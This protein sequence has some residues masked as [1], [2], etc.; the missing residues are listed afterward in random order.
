[1]WL[2]VETS[3]GLAGALTDFWILF[4]WRCSSSGGVHRLLPL[5]HPDLEFLDSL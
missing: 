3:Q 1:M 4:A 2:R 5:L